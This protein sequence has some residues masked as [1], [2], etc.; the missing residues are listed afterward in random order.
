MKTRALV[1]LALLALAPVFAHAQTPLPRTAGFTLAPPM[2]WEDGTALDCTASA[3]TYNIY[4]G[5]C[6]ATLTKVLSGE[7]NPASVKVPSSVPG[8]CFRATAV[9][10]GIESDQSAEV[11]YKGKPGAPAITLV[12]T[13]ELG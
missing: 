10:E 11:R 5:V 6:G 2:K 13:I 4:R 3:C 7:T 8:Q 9:A 12:I 1:L